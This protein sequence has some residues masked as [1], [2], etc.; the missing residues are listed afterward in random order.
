VIPWSANPFP[1]TVAREIVTLLEPEFSNFT[2]CEFVVPIG[3]L[4]KLALA[5]VAVKADSPTPSPL[6]P[7]VTGESFALLVTFKLPVTLPTTFGANVT[8][9]IVVCPGAST[10]PLFPPLAVIPAP[11]V[12]IPESVTLEVPVFLN[13]TAK[14][15]ELPTFSFAKLKLAGVAVI[16]RVSVSP[17]P[18]T[19]TVNVL[20][21]ALLA[22][23]MLPV[24]Y[25]NAV[26][27]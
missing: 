26:G 3:T 6:S 13:V 12:V 24:T 5:G 11:L 15:C 18:L 10:V 20:F 23:E 4:P 7:I 9:T 19:G 25:P 2:V 27:V 8:S 14:V 1:L 22:I 17:V 21:D 16:V